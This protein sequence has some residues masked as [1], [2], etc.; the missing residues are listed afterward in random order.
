MQ[1]DIIF[2]DTFLGLPCWLLWLLASL[3]SGLLGY[4][5]GWAQYKPCCDK[6]EEVEEEARRLHAGITD[7]EAK[8]RELQYR[9]D[10]LDKDNTALRASL[11]QCEA[12]KAAL[13]AKILT[14][15]SRSR[16]VDP[17][18]LAFADTGSG[19]GGADY[20]ALI[21]LDN[22]Q[23]I[24]GIGPKIEQLLK[25]SGYTSWGA[26]AAAEY[27]DLKK[28]LED[29]GP[30]YRIHD[31]KSWPEQARLAAEGKWDELIQY[32]KFLDAGRENTGDFESDSKLEK[33]IAKK[34]GYS[35]NPND[36]KIV[37][38]I[39][40]KIEGLLHGAGIQTWSDLAA[41]SV[42]R[43]R[44]ILAEAGERYRLADPT[45]WPK[46][47]ELAASGNW[48]ELKEYQDFLSGG[49]DPS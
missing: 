3:L 47:A 28:V 22:L 42:D 12:D 40:P 25:N 11:N 4:L 35:T 45:S 27:D 43:L 16:S 9:R 19:G 2:L 48:D 24:E 14:T 21:G 37:E 1:F 5:I 15:E 8:Y 31:P 32:Q 49:K 38:G 36:L 34:M 10:E 20:I 26:L 44:E 13:N 23:I 33:L 30:R 6:V 17:G 18:A 41:T 29:A 46:Q 39:G 7:W